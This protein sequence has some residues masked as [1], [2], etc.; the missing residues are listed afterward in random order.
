[1]YFLLTRSTLMVQ[2]L[3]LLLSYS[4]SKAFVFLSAISVFTSVIGFSITDLN[5]IQNWYMTLGAFIVLHL[6]ILAIL[7]MSYA[8]K[9]RFGKVS[10]KFNDSTLTIKAGNILSSMNDTYVVIPCNSTYDLVVDNDRLS[11]KS[12]QA[13]L[14]KIYENDGKKRNIEDVISN[15]NHPI[16]GEIQ[17]RNKETH[18]PIGTIKKLEGKYMLL[19]FSELDSQKQI[20]HSWQSYDSCLR[21]MW[22][23]IQLQH[24]QKEVILPLLGGGHTVFDRIPDNLNQELLHTI[25]HTFATTVEAANI[26]NV[27]ILLQPKALLGMNLTSLSSRFKK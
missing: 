18:Y 5:F 3:K 1:M 25:I 15:Q 9:L 13:K 21:V 8:A 27:T 23:Q 16:P 14:I 6:F 12:L 7:M 26:K 10:F 24:Q 17:Y 20:K 11:E 22:K 4:T 19:S 2:I